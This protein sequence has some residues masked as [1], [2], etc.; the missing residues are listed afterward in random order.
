M[1]DNWLRFSKMG[2]ILSH[3]EK[4]CCLLSQITGVSKYR[5][6]HKR[7]ADWLILKHWNEITW[8]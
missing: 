3:F 7:T 2:Y 6:L 8:L 4:S 1:E 5:A